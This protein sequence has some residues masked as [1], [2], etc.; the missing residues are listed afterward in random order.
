MTDSFL[1]GARGVVHVGANSGRERDL[2][3]R[4]GLRVIWI[5]P[6]PEVFEA[7]KANLA[8]YDLQRAFCAL[9]TDVDGAEYAFNIASN[10]GASSSIL[11]LGMHRDI[12]PGVVYEGVVM[13]RSATL[14]ALLAREAI[15]VSE[16]D[17]MVLDTQGS[18]LHVLRGAATILR[19][20]RYIK[21]EVADFESYANCCRVTDV[22]RFMALYGFHEV[23]RERFAGRPEIGWYYNIVYARG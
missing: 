11:D 23:D 6:I 17:V 7:L 22:E 20:F 1:A 18:E 12:W 9:I 4:H 10:H 5:E 16:Y 13:L 14:P 2:Y 8:A 21:V 3:A 19:G 15:D